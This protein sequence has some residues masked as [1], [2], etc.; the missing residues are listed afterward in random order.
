VIIDAG[1]S[2]VVVTTL[3]NYTLAPNLE[4]LAYTGSGNFSGTGNAL[5][6]WLVSGAGNDTLNGGPGN[7][8]LF[9]GAGL[10]IFAFQQGQAQGDVVQDFAGNGAA[11]GDSLRFTGFGPGATLS[12]VGATDYWT[13]RYG[14]AQSETLRLVGVTALHSTDYLFA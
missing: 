2:D 4:H 1:G 13:I 12:Q 14:I 7:D 9:G 5:N 6:N 10:D 11:A 8:T 3:A